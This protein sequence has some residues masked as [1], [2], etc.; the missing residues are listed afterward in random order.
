MIQEFKKPDYNVVVR[1]I[2]GIYD[3]AQMYSQDR[4]L[5]LEALMILPG[6]TD[7]SSPPR[8]LSAFA[9]SHLW[10]RLAVQGQL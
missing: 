10:K 9:K 1:D 7:G 5:K 6:Q 3:I 4:S 2:T 8:L